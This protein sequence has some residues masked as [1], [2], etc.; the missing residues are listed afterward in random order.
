MA[1]AARMET[2]ASC[3]K[4][5]RLARRRAPADPEDVEADDWLRFEQDKHEKL[6]A[7]A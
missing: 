2:D 4:P 1:F 7:A 3:A 5:Y 6:L